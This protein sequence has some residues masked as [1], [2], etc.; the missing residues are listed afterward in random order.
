MAGRLIH[1][2]TQTLKKDSGAH[3]TYDLG[4]TFVRAG[5]AMLGLSLFVLVLSFFHFGK[6]LEY[7]G[8]VRS[9]LL[10]VWQ[11]EENHSDLNFFRELFPKYFYYIVLGYD[12]GDRHSEKTQYVTESNFEAYRG[13]GLGEIQKPMHMYES[14][15]EGYIFSLKD[16]KGAERDFREAYPPIIDLR[17]ISLWILILSLPVFFVG[18]G[19]ERLAMKY[20]RNDVNIG[21]TALV[22]SEEETDD[23]MEEFERE[24][25][26][27][28]RNWLKDPPENDRPRGD[29]GNDLFRIEKK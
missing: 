27:H 22:L 9:E 26:K 11:V 28:Y 16:R 13:M 12:T 19:E 1:N 2:I 25:S 4:V 24:Y 15:H 29:N 17:A 7:V 3:F 6:R 23:L 10:G 18:L 8:D 20:P 21:E 5:V 14:A